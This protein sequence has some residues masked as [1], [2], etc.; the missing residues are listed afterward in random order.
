MVTATDDNIRFGGPQDLGGPSAWALFPA[1]GPPNSRGMHALPPTPSPSRCQE[2]PGVAGV[3]GTSTRPRPGS[4]ETI[5][6]VWLRQDPA[7]K[8]GSLCRG[9]GRVETE[10]EERR[11]KRQ[12][13]GK[14]KT[15]GGR[16]QS[17]AQTGAGGPRDEEAL[18]PPPGLSSLVSNVGI[19]VTSSCSEAVGVTGLTR[20]NHAMSEA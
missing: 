20:L 15:G 11:D 6:L 9:V 16:G 1:P 5:F 13:V 8:Q 7:C 3:W 2:Q 12:R 18:T 17:A 19:T 4:A 14:R 10:G